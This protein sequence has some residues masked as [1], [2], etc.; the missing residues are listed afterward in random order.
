M[1]TSSPT[2]YGGKV[3][4]HGIKRVSTFQKTSDSRGLVYLHLKLVLSTSLSCYHSANKAAACQHMP[5]FLALQKGS[6]DIVKRKDTHPRSRA[7]I[8]RLIFVVAPHSDSVR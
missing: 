2:I 4:F 3:R 5:D 1:K 7:N 8:S 6:I